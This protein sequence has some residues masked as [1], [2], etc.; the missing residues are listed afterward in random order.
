GSDVATARLLLAHGADPRAPGAVQLAALRGNTAT[1]ALLLDHGAEIDAQG[2]LGMTPLMWAAQMGRADTVA[3]LL[4]RGADPDRVETFD[5]ETALIQAAASDR[6]GAPIV[7]ALLDAHASTVPVD[8]EGASALE[9]AIRRGDPDII[10]RLA[11]HEA[12]PRPIHVRQPHGTLAPAATPRAALLRAIPLL[13]RAGPAWRRVAGC[14]SCHH[15]ALPALALAHAL[16]HGLP[17]DLAARTREADATAAFFRRSRDR[18]LEGV[19]FADVVECGYLLV[20]LAASDY[21]AGD[22][23]AA[24]ARY[25]ALHQARDGRF[26]AMM[27][28]E[29]VDGSDVALTAIAV[30]ALSVYAPDP[31]RIARARAYL[32]GVAATTTEDRAYQ[33]LGLHDAGAASAELAPLAARLAATQR[34]DGGF[35]QLAGLRS[36]AYATGQAIV[37]LREAGAYP[38]SDP[39]IRRAV[40]FLLAHQYRDGS[41]FVATRALRFQPFLTSG[42]PHGRS[43]FSSI[44]GT[45]WA[46]MALSD[47]L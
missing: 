9:W 34:A 21:P 18:F 5:R 24:M 11:A 25:L 33:L 3:L 37:A 44:A 35:A 31:A 43:Q 7:Q 12:T 41:W 1:L 15:D 13:E 14:P 36:D 6:A 10:Q 30:R 45:A 40:A 23:T 42:F 29:P 38:T 4:A 8:D 27:Q 20:G 2:A 47:A 32:T 26:P 28:R 39:V 17:I 46:V 19:G 22:L 16:H